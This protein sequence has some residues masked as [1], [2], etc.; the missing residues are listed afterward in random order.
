[1]LEA[2]AAGW[3][4]GGGG[5]FGFLL[6]ALLLEEKAMSVTSGEKHGFVYSMLCY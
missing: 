4:K 3:L 5:A 1:M 6:L 2:G